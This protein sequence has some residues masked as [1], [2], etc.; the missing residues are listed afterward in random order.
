MFLQFFFTGLMLVTTSYHGA[1]LSFY[2]E[3]V[4]G[5]GTYDA[6][7]KMLAQSGSHSVSFI[8]PWQ[9]KDIRSN[10]ISPY[11]DQTARDEVLRRSIRKAKALGLSVMLMPLISLNQA[12]PGEWRGRLRP[13]QPPMFWR[14]YR[15]FV[16]RYAALAQKEGV[17]L[18]SVGSELSSLE[19]EL[20]QWRR[21][22]THVRTVFSG[23]LIYSANWDHFEHVPFWEHLD[24]VGIS[25]YFE[26]TQNMT[27]SVEELVK[28]WTQIRIVVLDWLSQI[29]KPLIFTELG[30]PSCDGGA[31]FPWD[32]TQ[33]TQIDLEEQR[34][35]FEAFRRV[36]GREP[37]LHGVYFWNWWGPDDGMNGWYTIP[38]KP[39]LT[40]VKQYF[41]LRA[42]P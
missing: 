25:G 18:F 11:V 30:Y 40:E 28:S 9:L 8:V 3:N 21:L 41:Q 31:V 22:I 4:N 38:G 1:T 14:S 23:S 24:Y 29:S 17:S 26:L 36:W 32:Y 34:R 16:S 19:N 5:A 12:A 42:S 13:S 37:K 20:G 2:G 39:A 33:K 6:R 35:A 10:D 15:N 27:A 7:L